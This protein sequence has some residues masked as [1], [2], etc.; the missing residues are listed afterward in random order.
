M[1]RRNS[2]RKDKKWPK[3]AHCFWIGLNAPFNFQLRSI[4]TQWI[5]YTQ[6]TSAEG[7]H[8]GSANEAACNFIR[9]PTVIVPCPLILDEFL[10][11]R[12]HTEA[13]YVSIQALLPGC[14]LGA[15]VHCAMYTDTLCH[16]HR[17]TD[18]MMLS[19]TMKYISRLWPI[20]L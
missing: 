16:V 4:G 2:L 20:C 10:V 18:L 11:L 8:R 17:Y 5:S 19:K 12:C 14:G 3:G 6:E 15:A 13:I 7:K 9:L 1:R